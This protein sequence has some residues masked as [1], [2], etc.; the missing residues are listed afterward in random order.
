MVFKKYDL[1]PYEKST[2]TPSLENIHVT[3]SSFIFPTSLFRFCLE[4]TWKKPHETPCPHLDNPWGSRWLTHW[5]HLQ[6]AS[7]EPL[8]RG[9]HRPP[10]EHCRGHSDFLGDPKTKNASQMEHPDQAPALTPT[11]P[12]VRTPA[13]GD[14]L[15]NHEKMSSHVPAHLIRAFRCL[16]SIVCLFRYHQPRKQNDRWI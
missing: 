3:S 14:T 16:L 2:L 5:S 6:R 11:G 8:P 9:P 10:A 12:T 13:C 15:G 1:L 4:K 7:Q